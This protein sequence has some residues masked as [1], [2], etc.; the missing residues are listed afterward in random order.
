MIHVELPLGENMRGEGA[1]R[2]SYPVVTRRGGRRGEDR[3]LGFVVTQGRGKEALRDGAGDGGDGEVLGATSIDP[4]R[5][6]GGAWR[7]RA[8][9]GGS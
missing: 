9:R 8:A 7:K 1:S 5:N 4:F 3:Y 6:A 2:Y